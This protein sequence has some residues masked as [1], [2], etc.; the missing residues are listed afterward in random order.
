M[1]GGPDR[2]SVAV[3]APAFVCFPLWVAEERGMFARHDLEVRVEVAGATDAVT[4][5]VESGRSQLGISAGEGF[6]AAAATGGTL[7]IVAGNANRAPLR[8]VARPSIT[9]IGELRG[10]RIGTSSLREGTAVMSKEVLGAHGL[11]YPGD[12]E[13]VLAGAHPQR[14]KALQADEI[15][16]CLQLVPFDYVAEDAG[17][18]VLG[19]VSDYLPDYVFSAVGADLAW[20]EP[21]ADT[22]RRF[23]GALSEATGW[24]DGNRAEAA[25][26]LASA[27]G[28]SPAY[29]ARGLGDLIDGGVVPADLRVS[30]NGLDAMFAAM[31][32]TG[33]TGAETVLSFEKCVDERFLPRP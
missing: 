18:P 11:R 22:V 33:F 3:V 30:R 24:A 13:F 28:A 8:L 16:A 2:I 5:A 12:Y 20:A 6:A 10:K 29:A 4:S 7:R 27:T 14:W 32:S 26:I 31:R 1:S 17:Y 25:G 9:T 15:D 21:N 19:A 23:L